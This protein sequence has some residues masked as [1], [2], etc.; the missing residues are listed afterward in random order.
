[1]NSQLKLFS[2]GNFD[3]KF[4]H[5]LIIGIL[6]LSFSI[7]FLIRSLPADYGW[8]LNEFDPFFNYR[9]TQHIVENGIS[10]YLSWNDDLSW[11][12]HGRDIS[13]TSQSMLHIITAYTYTLFSS[14]IDLYD[15][16]IIFPVII[17]SLSTIVIF[18]V[19][20]EIGGT[21]AGLLSS[22]LFSV[23]LAITVRGVIGWF[24]SEPLGLF[25]G[26]LS[27]F[28]L[29]NSFNSKFCKNSIIKIALSGIFLSLSLSAWG[30]NQFFIILVGLFFIS[31]PFVYK[32]KISVLKLLPL[33]SISFVV[34]TALSERPGINF[35]FG[36]GG[37][38]ILGTTI[39]SMICILIQKRNIKKLNFKNSALILF[40]IVIVSSIFILGN[41]SFNPLNLTQ[42]RYLNAIYPLFTT[43]DPLI[44]SVSEHET[45]SLN[46]SFQFH[47]V[48]MIFAGIGIWLLF[49]KSNSLTITSHSKSFLLILV[50]FGSYIGSAFMRLEVFTSISII[51]I[52]SIGI[53][54]LLKSFRNINSSKKTIFT[55]SFFTFI[56][57]IL[58][59]PLFL[60]VTSNV[61]YVSSA[62]PPT[63]LNGGT[64]FQ[65]SFKDWQ[66]TLEWINDNTSPDAVIGSWWDYGYWIQTISERKTLADN[67][68]LIDSRIK[69]I[70]KIFFM[71][72]D[73]AWSSLNDLE[74]DYFVLFVA[75]ENLK[76]SNPDYDGIFLL[77]GGGDESKK[78]WFGKIAGIPM[79]DYFYPDLT[80]SSSK[81][82]HNTFLGK[83][84][85]FEP[86]GYVDNSLSY[87]SEEYQYG[88]IGLY[89]KKIKYPVDS[90]GP[91]RL[92]YSSSSFNN[93]REGEP[94][95]GV[96]VYEINKDYKLE[97]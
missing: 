84:I 14:G 56:V 48:L 26:L 45:L 61:L 43:T 63:I 77:G 29:L 68:T 76:N 69:E 97:N 9:A 1:M 22:L 49:K 13:L 6:A 66:E 71:K 65:G 23:S 34:I 73:D 16:T 80:S 27:I 75:G 28:L 33:F 35:I 19:T 8:E 59:V 18:F 88:M 32:E 85:P 21:T 58:L 52:S 17:G 79:E 4:N 54:L 87:F 81:F 25:L 42:H 82:W 74:T 95:I 55:Y 10:S 83:L 3:F 91:F 41:D 11:Y 40:S 5:I 37:L 78:L 7:S 50:L 30:G 24:K 72:P 90:D 15:Y 36:F 86:I 67:S 60:P 39:F 93:P 94:L 89:E 53:T 31:L 70:A 46:V 62:M 12:P 57:V 44:D 51:I 64:N 92:V 2:I 38:M 20:R 47:S 96:F